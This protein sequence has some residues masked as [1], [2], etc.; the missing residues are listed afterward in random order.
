MAPPARTIITFTT[1]FG[2]VDGWVAAMKGV[3]LSLAPDAQ[4]VDVTHAVPP[5]D[6]R[7]GAFVLGTTWSAFPAGTIHVAV[8]DPGV[9]T[10]RRGLALE[11]QGHRFVG[12]D[13]GLFT[14]P[15]RMAEAAGAPVRAV[16]L[17]RPEFH[18]AEVSATFHG[19]D[20]FAP[21]AGHLAAGRALGELGSAI[22]PRSL[23]RLGVQ[24]AGAR[25]EVLHVD[26]FGNLI[27][28]LAP[29]RTPARVRLPGAGPAAAALRLVRTFAD[30]PPGEAAALVGSSGLV[31]IVVNQGHAAQRFAARRGD[32]VELV[33]E[34]PA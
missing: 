5:Q 4:L 34:A 2:L 27:T 14:F 24:A 7:A 23:V 9:G 17:D 31:E 25:G 11:M 8:V 29:P 28:S 10:G 20:V 22:D 13:N 16:S 15:L 30:V 19:R 3:V 12:P 26:R 6:V 33:P 21:V 32:P 18:A 1:D